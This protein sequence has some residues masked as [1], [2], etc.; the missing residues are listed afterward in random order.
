MGLAKARPNYI[1]NPRIEQTRKLASL[2]IIIASEA[3]FLV[4]SMARSFYIYIYLFIYLFIYICDRLC[5]NH[6]STAKC[7]FFVRPKIVAK[8]VRGWFLVNVIGIIY[9]VLSTFWRSTK[10]QLSLVPPGAMVPLPCTDR[11]CGD[12]TGPRN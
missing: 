3:S 4:C 7:K 5:I 6:P 10:R 2:A 12:I 1:E 9:V 8:S 11:E